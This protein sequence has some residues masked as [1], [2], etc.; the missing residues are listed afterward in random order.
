MGGR[1][2][3]R[4]RGAPRYIFQIDRGP[5]GAVI[6]VLDTASGDT[7]REIPV[8]EFVAYAKANRDV[9]PLLLGLGP[10]AD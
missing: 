5:D 6:R 8:A 7:F 9:R 4:R 2:G 10:V 1:A 3:A